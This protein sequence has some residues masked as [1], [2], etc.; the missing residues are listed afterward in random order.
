MDRLEVLKVVDKSLLNRPG[1]LER[2]QQEIRSA[3]RL[4]HPNI[5]AAYSVLRPGDWLVFAMEY[6][7]GHDLSKVVN[8]R[9]PL[10]VVNVAVY[11]N[12]VALGLQHAHEKGMVHRDIKPNNLMLALDGKKHLIKI[13]DF[14]LAKAT[15]E[16]AADVWQTKSGQML[17]TPDYVAPEQMLDA[18][19]AD[20]RADIY[21]LG[22]TIYYLLTGHPPFQG[23]SLFEILQAHHTVEATRLN[24]VRP[25]V[26]EE[27]AAVV[28]KMMS[29][30]SAS[31]YQTPAEVGQALAPFFKAA[32]AGGRV[33]PIPAPVPLVAASGATPAEPLARPVAIAQEVTAAIPLGA[34]VVEQLDFGPARVESPK[35]RPKRLQITASQSITIALLHVIL[36]GAGVVFFTLFTLTG[37]STVAVA[38]PPPTL[39]ELATVRAVDKT[40]PAVK[41][42]ELATERKP[43]RPEPKEKDQP[44]TSVLVTSTAPLAN[45]A[46]PP[47]ASAIVS[48]A[49]TITPVNRPNSGSTLPASMPPSAIAPFDARQARAHQEAWARYLGVPIE[50]TN[51]LGMKLLLIPPGNFMMGSTPE[52]IEAARGDAEKAVVKPSISG[53]APRIASTSGPNQQALSSR[54]N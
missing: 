52:Q 48:N 54:D 18:Q 41:P 51:S 38:P 10:P 3:A 42:D 47:L 20:I 25:D 22:C 24:L 34:P 1:A 46:K 29:K 26:P 4:S 49:R 31:R 53:A 33:Q 36:L 39:E 23:N 13:L 32:G 11:G 17:G 7:S 35:I 15:S 5:V 16:K 28:A 50:Q 37:Q 30:A 8:D 43:I 40:E 9:G 12:Q 44:S 14:G 19:K 6:V 21:S 2:F 27:F 45:Q